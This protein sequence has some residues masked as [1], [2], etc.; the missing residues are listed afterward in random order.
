[1][2]A[3]VT[4]TANCELDIKRFYMEGVSV[5]SIC[6]KCQRVCEQDLGSSYLSYPPTNAAFEHSFYCNKCDTEWTVDL[7]L[8]VQLIAV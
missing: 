8:N 1:M 3:K 5:E 2:K 7:Q 6:P 4:G